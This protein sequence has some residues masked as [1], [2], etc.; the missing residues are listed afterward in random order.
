MRSMRESNL[1]AQ[2]ADNVGRN[3]SGTLPFNIKMH[4]ETRLQDHDTSTGTKKR[5]HCIHLC[6]LVPN[7]FGFFFS[8]GSCDSAVYV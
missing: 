4:P 6:Y 7:R 2:D 1:F 5:S 8:P 3:H